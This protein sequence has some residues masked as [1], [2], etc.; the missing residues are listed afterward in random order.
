MMYHP[1]IEV[2]LVM[3]YPAL[4]ESRT[5]NELASVVDILPTTL[6]LMGFDHL[7]PEDVGGINLLDQRALNGRAIL[8]ENYNCLHIAEPQGAVFSL[9]DGTHKLM[10]NT[11]PDFLE[12]FP[13][14]TLLIE[15][16]SDPDEL[17]DLHFQ[18]PDKT[19]SMLDSMLIH[20]NEWVESIR[21]V[22]EDQ[23]TVDENLHKNL[24]ALGYVN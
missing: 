7:L 12:K 9:F 17:V 4:I 16:R 6:N 24:K 22:G 15:V 18:Y 11:D 21:V 1:A 2:P 14:D 19:D 13:F 5:E 23:T 8:A 10:L 20:M 3:R